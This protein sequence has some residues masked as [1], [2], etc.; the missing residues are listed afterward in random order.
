MP[1][2]SDLM[3]GK[4][5]GSVRVRHTDWSFSHYFTPYYELGGNWYGPEYFLDKIQGLREVAGVLYNKEGYQLY[6]EPK[7]KK[8]MC[9]WAYEDRQGPVR[10]LKLLIAPVD[11]FP[12]NSFEHKIPNTEFEVDE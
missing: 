10:T 6:V 7:P 8:K 2:I 5:P 4:V 12:G 1:T 9:L 3:E 11:S